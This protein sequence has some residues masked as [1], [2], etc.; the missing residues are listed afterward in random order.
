[1]SQDDGMELWQPAVKKHL[2]WVFTSLFITREIALPRTS[3]VGRDLRLSR[4]GRVMKFAFFWHGIY[5]EIEC[6]SPHALPMTFKLL[7]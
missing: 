3:P 2:L 5:A 7:P 1:M 4:L 6:T